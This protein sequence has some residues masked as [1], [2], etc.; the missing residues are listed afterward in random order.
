KNKKARPAGRAISEKTVL[1]DGLF[2]W[3]ILVDFPDGK[4]KEDS[5]RCGERPACAAGSRRASGP[6]PFSPAGGNPLLIYSCEKISP[7][8]P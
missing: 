4:I 1:L 6:D 2:L 8:A 5:A 7:I 3:F